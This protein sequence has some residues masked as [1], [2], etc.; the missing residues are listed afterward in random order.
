[1]YF[2]LEE[3]KK[4]YLWLLDD[5][6]DLEISIEPDV[7]FFFHSDKTPTRIIKG[8]KPEN[9][10]DT[11]NT[12]FLD[13]KYEFGNKTFISDSDFRE[14]I[15]KIHG[16][17]TKSAISSDGKTYTYLFQFET[18]ALFGIIS[19][20]EYALNKFDKHQKKLLKFYCEKGVFNPETNFINPS[21]LN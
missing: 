4:Q 14:S 8:L 10:L 21:A 18:K 6:T 2:S 17:I 13:P 16:Y 20:M 9:L 7:Q 1:M 19:E 11:W 12:Y 3:N 5:K 15:S